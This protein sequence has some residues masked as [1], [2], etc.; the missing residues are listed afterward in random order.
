MSRRTFRYDNETGAMVEITRHYDP[1]PTAPLVSGD[2]PDYQSPIDGR[3]ISGRAARREDLK[4]SG[5]VEYEPSMKDAAIR[6]RAKAD[7]DLE[8]KVERTVEK[9]FYETCNSRQREL[10]VQALQAGL[11]TAIVRR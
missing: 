1:T 6:E 8:R 4:R 10:I 5:C 9:H 11:G 3:L 2:L 7:A